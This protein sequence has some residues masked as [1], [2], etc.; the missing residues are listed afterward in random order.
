[1][2]KLLPL[3]LIMVLGFLMSGISD[4][5]AS[6]ADISIPDNQV[7]TNVSGSEICHWR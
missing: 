1:M 4:T 2:K 3:V 7:A 6:I 5:K